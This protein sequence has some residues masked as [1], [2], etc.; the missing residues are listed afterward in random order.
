MSDTEPFV[1]VFEGNGISA[2]MEAQ[3]IHALLESSGVE[4]LLVRENVTEIPV[5]NVEVRVAGSQAER[6]REII[7]AGRAAGPEAAEMAE[8]ETEL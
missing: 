3:A 7:E 4:S 8:A 6:A 5:G 1:T 2:E